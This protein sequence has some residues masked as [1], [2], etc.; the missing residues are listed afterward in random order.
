MNKLFFLSFILLVVA[1]SK[2]DIKLETFSPEAF[3]YDLG[4]KWEVNAMV[5]VRG[6]EQ[7][8]NAEYK[9][10]EASIILSADLK[11]TDGALVERIFA[12]TINVTHHEEI[13]DIPLEV[14]FELDS[15]YSLGRY[16][17]IIHI[18]DDFSKNNI[19]TTVEFELAD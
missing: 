19:T 14:Q 18:T 11:A 1:C 10:I 7:R 9:N 17:I 8:E 15:T 5:N 16:Q 2:D 6:F 4:D 12:D 13:L 3:A